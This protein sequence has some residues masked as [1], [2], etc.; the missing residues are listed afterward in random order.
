MNRKS[1]LLIVALVCVLTTC[2]TP[3][4]P[5]IGP[6]PSLTPTR[7]FTPSSTAIPTI[8]SATPTMM[9]PAVD[10]TTLRGKVIFGYQGWYSCPG[11]G[12]G[13]PDWIHWFD[14][15]SPPTTASL[16]VDFWPD[17]SELT[18]GER[19][20]TDITLSNGTPL[21][22]YSSYNAQ[23]VLRH[24]Q[25]MAEYGIDGAELERFIFPELST[26]DYE[27]RNQVLKNV[28]F[29]A[30]TYG[31]VFSIM[32]DGEKHGNLDLLKKD[33]K[34][35]VDELKVTESPQYLHHKGLPLVSIYGFGFNFSDIDPAEAMDLINFFQSNPNP[36]YRATVVGGIPSYWRTLTRD[37]QSDPAWAEVYR[38]FNVI[39]PMSPGRFTN[40]N[41]AD[42]Y[43]HEVIIPDLVETLR[44]GIEYMPI[45]QPGYSGANLMAR[46]NEVGRYNE[47]PRNGG[48]FYWRQVY[49]ALSAGAL[50]LYASM[51]NEVDEGMAMFKLATSQK[52][53]PADGS[54][55][56]LDIDGYDLT[57]D[58][59]LQLGCETGRM[60]R[61]ERTLSPDFPLPGP[62]P[63][64]NYPSVKIQL[65][66]TDESDGMDLLSSVGDGLNRSLWVECTPGRQTIPMNSNA[67]ASYLYF[68]VSDDFYYGQ[69]KPID[70]YVEFYDEGNEPIYLEYDAAPLGSDWNALTAYKSIILVTRQNSRTWRIASV[71]L[72]DAYFVGHQ[73]GGADFR[74]GTGLTPLTV[75][76][77]RLQKLS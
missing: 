43:M 36:K 19:C 15:N 11:D 14:Y 8:P 6:T 20:V 67:R 69:P 5:A 51:F 4:T 55:V 71:H 10:A 26:R 22:A 53:L 31:R 21:V 65:G 13:Y 42:I 18:S 75:G 29:G 23:T 40:N 60:L 24:F 70:V 45:V 46:R 77:V 34:Y 56:P 37:S 2:N 7:T 48:K 76:Y 39:R 74:L 9:A 30:E 25:W 27:F 57:S 54:L 49:N 16:N 66:F 68:T 61:G 47:I 63:T 41:Q 17:T 62:L 32:Y 38:S 58:W 64:S 12:A 59:Y 28:R 3:S 50:M 44:F 1:L 52:D 33:W 72:E 35:L 73:N